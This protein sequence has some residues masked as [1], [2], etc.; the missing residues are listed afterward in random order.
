MITMN[1]TNHKSAL[2]LFCSLFTLCL[3]AQN[4]PLPA[5]GEGA[6]DPLR[7]VEQGNYT[8]KLDSIM[9][10]NSM[11]HGLSTFNYYDEINKVATFINYTR[12]DADYPWLPVNKYE[13]TY[14]SEGNEIRSIQYNSVENEWVAIFKDEDYYSGDTTISQA[15]EWDNGWVGRYRFVSIIP[16]ENTEESLYYDW[17]EPTGDWILLDKS[18]RLEVETDTSKSM[19]FEEYSW[20]EE[21]MDWVLKTRSRQLSIYSTGE[22]LKEYIL[23]GWD[24]EKEIWV[25]NLRDEYSF[26]SDDSASFVR[27]R[28]DPDTDIWTHTSRTQ[29]NHRSEG[30]F[31]NRYFEVWI[32]DTQEWELWITAR[33]LFNETDDIIL[34]ELVH[35]FSGEGWKHEYSVSPEG[36]L[37]NYNYYVYDTLLE[38]K[39]FQLEAHEYE[40]DLDHSLEQ[41]IWPVYLKRPQKNPLTHTRKEVFAGLPAVGEEWYYFSGLN[42]AVPD[43]PKPLALDTWPNP[44]T[45]LI[46][47]DAGSFDPDASVRILDFNG[48]ILSDQKLGF[49]NE[50]NIR[51]YQPGIYMIRIM[52]RNGK[53]AESKFIKAR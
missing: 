43:Y 27:Y 45:D 4:K 26:Y 29:A 25:D 46:R 23:S 16:D 33:I 32:E 1:V 28:R 52:D 21:K 10:I 49:R 31:T 44:S 19:I 40:Y 15:F 37:S 42:S 11:Y 3:L 36:N 17:D 47:F 24:M 8:G 7:L 12:P 2:T 34:D 35:H 30:F 48:R 22:Y 38:E 41:I 51:E 39:W 13:Y 53:T 20:D 18:I 5:Q 6:Q 14:D 9:E 50:I